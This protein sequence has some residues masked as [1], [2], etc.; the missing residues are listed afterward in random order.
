MMAKFRLLLLF[1]F[2]FLS[3]TI[4]TAGQSTVVYLPVIT[5]SYCAIPPFVETFDQD[6]GNWVLGIASSEPFAY[7]A[8]SYVLQLPN[9]NTF[10]F[11]KGPIQWSNSSSVTL[12]ATVTSGD[13]LWGLTIDQGAVFW[14]FGVIPNTGEWFVQ[15][16]DSQTPI[17]RANNAAIHS[18]GVNQIELRWTGTVID[19]VVNDVT[20]Y[21]FTQ[22]ASGT[23]GLLGSTQ[24]GNSTIHFDNF[25]SIDRA[26]FIP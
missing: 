1:L 7:Q 16:N 8:G 10:G 25:V 19:M 9:A 15:R 13:G 11:A 14:T 12:E 21:T 24:V 5:K 18:A 6:N 2:V 20:V 26:C 22:S 4:T 23:V 17:A 3:H